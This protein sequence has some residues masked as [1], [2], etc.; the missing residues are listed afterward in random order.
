MLILENII[1]LPLCRINKFGLN[2][3]PSKTVA[4]PYTCGLSEGALGGHNPPGRARTPRHALVGCGPHVG[5]LTYLFTPHH[6]LPPGK[7]LH[8]YVSRVLALKPADFDLFARSFVSK[9]VLGDCYL[10]CNSP[11]APISFCFSGSYFE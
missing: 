1:W 8:C 4:I 3:L 6:H 5:P 10:V 2:T 9:T 11:I 7:I